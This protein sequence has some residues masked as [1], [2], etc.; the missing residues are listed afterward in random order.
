MGMLIQFFLGLK[1]GQIL[2]ISCGGGGGFKT[3]AI[4]LGYIKL[5]PQD[6]FFTHDCNVIFRNYFVSITRKICNTATSVHSVMAKF[7]DR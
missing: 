2:F 6:H 7:A 3:G 4:F 5:R 1:F